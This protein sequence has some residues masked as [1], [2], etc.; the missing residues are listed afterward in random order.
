MN[1]DSS[2][3]REYTEW[4]V[5]PPG[6]RR[7]HH[8]IFRHSVPVLQ[9]Y[10]CWLRP[11]NWALVWCSLQLKCTRGPRFYPAEPDCCWAAVRGFW[12]LEFFTI[13]VWPLVVLLQPRGSSLFF[14]QT[15]LSGSRTRPKG[16]CALKY[17][18]S[19]WNPQDTIIFL[20]FMCGL[21]YIWCLC[22]FFRTGFAPTPC[23]TLKYVSLHVSYF[24]I[25]EVHSK[26]DPLLITAYNRAL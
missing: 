11:V 14:K 18:K 10:G 15:L 8:K 22:L 1:N 6:P 21:F 16:F 23:Q 26:P 25:R 19:E 20:F 24:R 17:V 5:E 2:S 12:G 9:S 7:S 13:S 4:G 3:K